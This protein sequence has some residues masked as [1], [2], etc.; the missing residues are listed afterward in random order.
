MH[1]QAHYVQFIY[2]HAPT[3]E[4]VGRSGFNV[5]HLIIPGQRNVLFSK[6]VHAISI[7]PEVY[8]INL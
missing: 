6:T 1:I 4:Q 8:K 7:V 2:D 3:I 5:Y